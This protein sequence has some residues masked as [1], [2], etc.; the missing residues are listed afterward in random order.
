MDG[1]LKELKNIQ[2]IGITLYAF[3]AFFLVLSLCSMI[4]HGY[5][6][7]LLFILATIVTISLAA[8][9]SKKRLNTSMLGVGIFFVVFCLVVVAIAA[10]PATPVA[11]NNT[12][13]TA[14]EIAVHLSS[15]NGGTTAA[16]SRLAPTTGSTP[17]PSITQIET[18]TPA[19]PPIYET[20]KCQDSQWSTACASY[21]ARVTNDMKHLTTAAKNYDFTSVSTYPDTLYTDS[22]KAIE[23]SDLYNVSPDLQDTKNEYRSAMVQANMVAVYA[24]S[25]VEKYN[26]GNFITVNSDVKQAIE[27]V[28]SYNEHIKKAAKLSNNYES[29]KR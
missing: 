16:T 29:K 12:E 11:V 21:M 19:P 23:D 8:N 10:L 9:Q 27:C 5:I 20:T 1:I 14:R 28:N 13:N 26:N 15:V 7:G 6:E 22:Q 18:T 4:L 17:T 3:G 25:G 24:N 2:F